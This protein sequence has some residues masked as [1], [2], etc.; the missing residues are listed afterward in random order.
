MPKFTAREFRSPLLGANLRRNWS[1]FSNMEDLWCYKEKKNMTVLL[2]GVQRTGVA[3]F[4]YCCEA[5]N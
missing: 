5:V 2:G 1:N 4:L 3:L